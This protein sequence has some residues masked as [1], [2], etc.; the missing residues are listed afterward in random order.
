ML[1]PISLRRERRLLYRC[2]LWPEAMAAPE[3]HFALE[4]RIRRLKFDNWDAT[5]GDTGPCQWYVAGATVCS[6]RCYSDWEIGV[7]RAFGGAIEHKAG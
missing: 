7:L 2:Q 6:Q 3:R 4:Q 1:I 5:V